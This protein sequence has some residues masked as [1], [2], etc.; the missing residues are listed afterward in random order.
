LSATLSAYQA[1]LPGI[2]FGFIRS[3]EKK[4]DFSVR[5]I[6]EGIKE[7]QTLRGASSYAYKARE[8]RQRGA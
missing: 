1:G 5:A 3:H 6:Q 2:D 4:L 7:E 8:R